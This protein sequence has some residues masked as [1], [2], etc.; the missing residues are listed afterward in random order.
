[1][2][3]ILFVVTVCHMMAVLGSLLWLLLALANTVLSWSW[4]LSSPSALLMRGYVVD[5][6]IDTTTSATT[7]GGAPCRGHPLILYAADTSDTSRANN[8]EP[9]LPNFCANC[10]SDQMELRVPENDER[11][12]AVCGACG[13]IVY[14][15]P[16]IV[17]SCVVWSNDDEANGRRILLAKRA[18]EPRLGYWGIPQGFMEHGETT[19]D[20]A[21][22]EVQEETGITTSMTNLKLRA[23]Y[24]VPGSVQLLYEV[25]LP[26]TRERQHTLAITTIESSEIRWFSEKELP[27][28]ELCFPTVKWALEHCLSNSDQVQQRTK[29]YDSKVEQWTM[30]EDEPIN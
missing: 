27:Y 9:P 29:F 12:R 10:G 7:I 25:E 5:G 21:I 11:L 4:C 28:D 26:S 19:R 20:A 14:S 2:A 8:Y 30:I 22:R 17:V 16:K 18:I 3:K 15:N 23:V 24:N 6:T 13:H 1:M